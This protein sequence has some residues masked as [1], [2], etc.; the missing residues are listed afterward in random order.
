MSARLQVLWGRGGTEAMRDKDIEEE[1][2]ADGSDE[3]GW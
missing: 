1:N 3:G 2:K